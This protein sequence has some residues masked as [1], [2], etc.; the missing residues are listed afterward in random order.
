MLQSKKL[1]ADNIKAPERDP[2][3]RKGMGRLLEPE[4]E[5]AER[6][7]FK[8]SKHLKNNQNV[9][10]S[11]KKVNNNIQWRIFNQDFELTCIFFFITL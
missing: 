6:A 2:N 1:Y 9:M 11:K 7:R 4:A 8:N 5:H 10:K 3:G